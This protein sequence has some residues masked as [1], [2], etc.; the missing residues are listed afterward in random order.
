MPH[1][2]STLLAV[3]VSVS[4]LYLSGYKAYRLRYFSDDFS[5]NFVV[6]QTKEDE[7]R[8]AKNEQRSDNLEKPAYVTEPFL[9]HR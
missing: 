1:E 5:A 2:F 6:H 9:E 3:A 4:R 7:R 8:A